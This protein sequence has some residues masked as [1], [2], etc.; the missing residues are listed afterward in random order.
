MDV[1]SF[2]EMWEQLEKN[3]IKWIDEKAIVS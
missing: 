3:I 2:E 1:H